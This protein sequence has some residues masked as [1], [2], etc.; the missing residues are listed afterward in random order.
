MSVKDCVDHTS[1]VLADH[2]SSVHAV[3]NDKK[4]VE[5]T[6]EYGPY[7][8]NRS[9]GDNEWCKYTGTYQWDSTVRLYKTPGRVYDPS[10]KKFLS[11]DPN[12]Q[13]SSPYTYTA[14][15]PIGMY[16]QSGSMVTDPPNLRALASPMCQD[17]C[18]IN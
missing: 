3:I 12:R 13:Y 18:R 10:G 9:A 11:Q 14:N 16:D 7:G 15:N 8:E 4:E 1:Y 17:S 5:N 6:C 2:L